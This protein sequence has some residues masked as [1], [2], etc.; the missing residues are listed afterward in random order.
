MRSEPWRGEVGRLVLLHASRA[1]FYPRSLGENPH[2]DAYLLLSN[3]NR[4][5]PEV[6]RQVKQTE[7]PQGKG[8]SEGAPAKAGVDIAQNQ[9]LGMRQF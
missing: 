9:R 7:S 6:K 5:N 1:F 2:I 8:S 4:G 3:A